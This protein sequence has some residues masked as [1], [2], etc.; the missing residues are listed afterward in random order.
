MARRRKLTPPDHARQQDEL[1]REREKAEWDRVKQTWAEQDAI[2]DAQQALWAELD[3]ILERERAQN[4][5]IGHPREYK[6]DKIKAIIKDIIRDQ[7]K[8]SA[9]VLADKVSWACEHLPQYKDLACPKDRKLR[10]LVGDVLV[11]LG[12]KPPRPPKPRR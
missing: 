8:Q 1:R 2:F 12:L 4:R 10:T 7:G 11:E 3:A 6:D 9:V 5:A